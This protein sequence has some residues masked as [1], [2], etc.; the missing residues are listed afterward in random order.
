MNIPARLFPTGP[1]ETGETDETD[2]VGNDDFLL[3]IF[4]DEAG[5][6]HPLLVSFAGNPSTVPSKAWFGRPWLVDA[7]EAE[8]L[9]A[10]ANNYFSLAAFRPDEQGRYRRRKANFHALRAMMLDDVGATDRRHDRQPADDGHHRCQVVRSR[11]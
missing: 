6:R 9:T 4:G 8:S 1:V 2:M 7:N 5:D 11:R 10:S 3:A